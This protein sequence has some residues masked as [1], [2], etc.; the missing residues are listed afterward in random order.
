MLLKTINAVCAY[1]L[2]VCYSGVVSRQNLVQINATTMFQFR[3]IYRYNLPY[4]FVQT[5][6]PSA[7]NPV[8]NILPASGSHR[9]VL[10]LGYT[11]PSLINSVRTE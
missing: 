11:L 10:E 5:K 1:K 6:I 9:P 2:L 8:E 7:Y 4:A 3:L